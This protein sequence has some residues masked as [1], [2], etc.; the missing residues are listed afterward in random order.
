MVISAT[1]DNGSQLVGTIVDC[2]EIRWNIAPSDYW[3]KIPEIEEV[4]VVFMNHLD[5]GYNGINP[6]TGFINNVLN[7]YFD[8]Y[9]PRAV[10][11]GEEIVSKQLDIGF[12]YTT[13]PWLV[14]L[15]LNC[16]ANFTLNNITLHCPSASEILSF[17]SAIMKGY[18]HWHAGPMNMQMELMNERMLDIAKWIAMELDKKYKKDSPNRTRVWSQRDV[19]GMTKSVIKYFLESGIGAVS[20]G[21]NPDSSPPGVPK[22]FLWKENETD[23]DGVIAMW[24]K[25]GYPINPGVSLQKPGG[26]SVRDTIISKDDKQAL[27]FAFRTDNSGPPLSIEEISTSYEIIRGEY[28][29]AKIFASTIENFAAKVTKSS[30][31]VITDEIGDTWIQGV[32]SDPRKMSLYRAAIRALECDPPECTWEWDSVKD[33]AVF[34]VKLPEHTWGLPSAH[35]NEHWTNAA[36]N[37][38]RKYPNMANCEYSWKEQ[39]LFFNMTQNI[40]SQSAKW[41]ANN[42]E[43]ELQALNPTIPALDNFVVQS[44]DTTFTIKLPGDLPDYTI[45]LKFDNNGAISQLLQADDVNLAGQIGLLS[46][47]TYNGTDFDFMNRRYNYF[48][49]AGFSKPLSDEYAHPNS[50]IVHFIV[51]NLYSNKTATDSDRWTFLLELAG[52]PFTNFYYGMPEKAWVQI[53][54][55]PSPIP[56]SL[57]EINFD[58]SFFNKTS[59]RLPEATMFSF[60]PA[61][62]Y[63]AQYHKISDANPIPV[64]SVIF[65]GSQYQHA[66]ESVELQMI[67]D[68]ALNPIRIRFSS[69]DVP[70]V[71]PIVNDSSFKTP[72]PFPAPLQPIDLSLLKGFAFNIHNNI[73]NT[74]YPL[75]Y[76]FVDE[77]KDFKTRYTMTA[78]KIW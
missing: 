42:L 19:P 65:N 72:T 20:V 60:M 47:Y 63:K 50:S 35:D 27:V 51:K 7:K 66:V 14:Y 69:P 39:R 43:K 48:G 37:A 4:H 61:G 55:G 11:L 38:I 2:D 26:I 76:P 68:P 6:S 59:T 74:N 29:G 22:L 15:Y 17:E 70:L 33:F 21:V 16:P 36:F 58:V 31:P 53:E 12:I 77:D 23:S 3:F 67:V 62:S 52:D 24:N 8:E 45:L 57:F 13:H 78:Y 10:L 73:W 30:L 75:W 25:G 34:L 18:I 40:S 1:L 54:I 71:C 32:A 46:Y 41:Y 28:E 56:H 9:F 49:N 64:E 5:V 44:I